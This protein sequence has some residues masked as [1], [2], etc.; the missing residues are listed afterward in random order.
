MNRERSHY[1]RPQDGEEYE[2]ELEQIRC[3][4]FLLNFWLI[5]PTPRRYEDFTT[6]GMSAVTLHLVVSFISLM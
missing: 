3:V 5:S 2:E 1:M 6:I 4:S